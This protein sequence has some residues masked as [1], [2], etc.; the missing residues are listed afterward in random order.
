[1]ELFAS[2]AGG[3]KSVQQ[4]GTGMSVLPGSEL[5]AGIAPATLR[6]ARGGQVR[7]CPRS[8]LGVNASGQGLM[9]A[10]GTGAIE[11]DYQLDRQ[12]TDVVITPDFNVM[13]VGPGTFHFGLGVNK[14]GDTCVRP[15][16]GNS[17]E[18]ALTE[19]LGTGTYKTQPNEGALFPGGK[20]D[21]HQALSGVCG[22]PASLP[23]M[24]A[25]A[26]P[27]PTPAPAETSS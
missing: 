18:L 17:G 19:L 14:S 26:S 15:L 16:P 11:I 22:C 12:A 13:L 27:S 1:G 21:E 4:V 5:S 25:E 20:L 8:S 9:L 2:D 10:T 3:Q 23:V 24:R 7:I 6:L